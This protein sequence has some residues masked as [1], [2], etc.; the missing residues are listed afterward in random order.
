MKIVATKGNVLI[1]ID[2]TQKEKYSLTKA[3]TIHIEKGFNFNLREDKSS[4]G[5][6]I[7]GEGLPQGASILIHHNST[8]ATYEVPDKKFLTDEERKEGYKVFS[9]PHDTV[10]CFSVDGKKW[11]PCK[12]FLIT[13][14]IFKEYKGRLTGIESELVKDR[15]YIVQGEIE[16]APPLEGRVCIVTPN[17]AYEIIFHTPQNREERVIRTRAREI[18]AIDEILTQQVN[19]GKYLIGLNASTAKTKT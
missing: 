5:Y 14:R 8:N 11:Q 1:R 4:M 13:L 17:S 15:L 7:D 19:K 10:Y 18:L 16:D 3:I 2:V 12:D 9:I 6:V